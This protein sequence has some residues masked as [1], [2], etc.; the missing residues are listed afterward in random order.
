MP[1]LN[2]P[3]AARVLQEL[4]LSILRRPRRVHAG[5]DAGRCATLDALSRLS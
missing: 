2:G 5:F 3:E 4:E 1:E